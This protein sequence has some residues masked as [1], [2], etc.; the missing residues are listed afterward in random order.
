M[1]WFFP[2]LLVVCACS[3][4]VVTVS[5]LQATD[6]SGLP[7][8][9]QID[10]AVDAGTVTE[11]VPDA[12]P[13]AP[14]DAAPLVVVN[15]GAECEKDD[16]HRYACCVFDEVN[17]FRHENAV[18]LEDYLWDAEISSAAYYYA[19]YM[20]ERGRFAHGLD[21]LKVGSRLSNFGVDWS[22]AGEN[23]QRNT[24]DTWQE[25]CVSTLN[26]WA[27]STSGHREAMLDSRYTHGAVGVDFGS[28]GYW[29]VVMN[30]AKLR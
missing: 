4:G 18:G 12:R 5:D 30:F 21:G 14:V 1:K 22:A 9:P 17:R 29:Y 6:A 2:A 3:D 15:P 11:E 25:G 26:G 8:A 7:L 20:A 10:G 27:T 19:T 28:D 16:F 24:Y 13:V 23:I